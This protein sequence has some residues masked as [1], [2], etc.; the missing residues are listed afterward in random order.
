MLKDLC[1]PTYVGILTDIS[2]TNQGK[3]ERE[4]L[5]GK[6]LIFYDH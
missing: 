1:V 4:N 2:E 3:G 6:G 5:K